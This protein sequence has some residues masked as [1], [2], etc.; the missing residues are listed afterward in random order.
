MA[1]IGT[2]RLPRLF[3][4]R[5]GNTDWSDSHQHTGRTDIPLN[6]HGEAQA[7]G[8]TARLRGEH[9]ARVFTSPLVRARRTCEL[10]GF[11]EHAE[12]TPEL[13]EW[14]YGEYEGRRTE[15]IQRE[16]P[17]WNLFRHGAP[18]GES[19]EAVAARADQFIRL[20]RSVDGDAAAFSSGHIIRMIAARWLRLAPVDG[21]SFLAD[22]A[23]VSILG[24]EHNQDEPVVV[25]WNDR[26]P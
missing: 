25:R 13:V 7:R 17:D 23:S 11:A 18:G 22:T 15:D 24:Y 5:H 4:I 3:L 12:A 19:P 21:Q 16:R 6:A 26:R 10:A 2:Q 20:A 8:L 14:D 1:T 9:F